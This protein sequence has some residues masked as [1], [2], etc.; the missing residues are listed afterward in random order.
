MRMFKVIF[1]RVYYNYNI[2]RYVQRGDK[3]YRDKLRANKK[4]IFDCYC[5]NEFQLQNIKS[6]LEDTI[7]HF[8]NVFKYSIGYQIIV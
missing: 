5:V 8:D 1:Y 6:F 3:H 2:L 7:P 4:K